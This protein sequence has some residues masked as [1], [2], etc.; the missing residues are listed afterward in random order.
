MDTPGWRTPRLAGSHF[1]PHPAPHS[2][3]ACRYR[4]AEKT[5]KDEGFARCWRMAGT[6]YGFAPHPASG[7]AHSV[8][9]IVSG[10]WW[11]GD[12]PGRPHALAYAVWREYRRFFSPITLLSLPAI[13]QTE[14]QALQG[15]S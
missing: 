6:V 12:P 11:D 2:L 14:I 13:I 8:P 4:G 10:D 15:G 1:R 5:L 9:L 7:L 3:V